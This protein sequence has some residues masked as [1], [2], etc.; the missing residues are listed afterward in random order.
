MERDGMVTRRVIPGVPP[1]VEYELTDRAR[2]LQG[3]MLM[4]HQWAGKH[5][6]GI[7]RSRREFDDR[8]D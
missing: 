8:E 3:P 6:E 7:A 2:S 4:L 5:A 1:R